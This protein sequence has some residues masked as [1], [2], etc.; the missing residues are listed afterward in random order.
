MRVLLDGLYRA[1]AVLAAVFLV[2]IGLLILAQ[3]LGRLVGVVVPS[4]NELA[5][6]CMAA[7]SFLALAPTF[8]R[9]GHIR[10]SLVVARLPPSARLWTE[11]WCL[12]FAS[13]LIAYFAWYL[14]DLALYSA[15]H[16]R[17]SPG[18]LPIPL[19]IPQAGMAFG[20]VVLA[21]ALLES[22]VAVL[23]GRPPSYAEHEA[24]AGEPTVERRRRG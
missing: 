16:G 17:L 7:T 15:L 20:T 9:G 24:G 18:L 23:R 12:G 11:V 22:L 19:W 14:V 21:V 4:A 3:M 2:A 8:R 1:C 6:F 13:A 10:V 5:G